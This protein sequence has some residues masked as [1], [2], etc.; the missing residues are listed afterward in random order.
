MNNTIKCSRELIEQL[1]EGYD[2]P[3]VI[4]RESYRNTVDELKGLDDKILDSI[5]VESIE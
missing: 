4:K 2:E 5:D 1:K 3:K